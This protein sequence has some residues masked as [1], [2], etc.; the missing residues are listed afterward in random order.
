M[1][2]QLRANRG[3]KGSAEESMVAVT[4]GAM[5]SS[6]LSSFVS[7]AEGQ[8]DPLPAQPCGYLGVLYSTGHLLQ[9]LPLIPCAHTGSSAN[10]LLKAWISHRGD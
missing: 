9:P 1:K 6:K 2:H 10:L 7:F 4:D 5:A 8:S 3:P